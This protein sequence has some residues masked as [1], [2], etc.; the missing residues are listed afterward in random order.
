[1]VKPTAPL[2]YDENGFLT[3]MEHPLTF[4]TL[5]LVNSEYT[6][7][8]LKMADGVLLLATDFVYP[9]WAEEDVMRHTDKHLRILARN[10]GFEVTALESF[11]G[12]FTAIHC[13]LSRY[14]RAYPQQI[15]ASQNP[16]AKMLR[17]GILIGHIAIAPLFSLLGWLIYIS[18][19]NNNDCFKFTANNLIVCKK[20]RQA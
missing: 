3:T 15:T 13:E 4:D 14:V 8:V 19:R 7:K 20:R 12:I 2:M 5:P 11:G 9:K 10:A 6:N 1:M 16:L 17:V 18:D